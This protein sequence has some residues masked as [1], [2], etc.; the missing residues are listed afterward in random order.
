[1]FVHV[2]LFWQKEGAGP[3]VRDRLIRDCRELLGNIPTV[4]KL[5][6][7][8]PAMTPRDVVDNS[9]SVGLCVHF[10]DAAGHEV[11]QPHPQH[12]QFIANNKEHWERVRVYDFTT[13]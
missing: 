9:Y 12:L 13:A 4:R 3:A 1:M 7:G 11:Y 8:P 10:D 6:A 5:E 2:V